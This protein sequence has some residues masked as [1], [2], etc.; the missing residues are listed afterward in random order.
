MGA[1]VVNFE[2]SLGGERRE[3]HNQANAIR[4]EQYANQAYVIRY[5]E[6]SQDGEREEQ[7]TNQAN[8]V[9]DV[10]R[11]FGGKREEKLANQAN[12]IGDV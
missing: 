1:I 2:S 12:V 10:K 6:T 7:H 3:Q 5:F 4:G 9:R 8:V 11:H